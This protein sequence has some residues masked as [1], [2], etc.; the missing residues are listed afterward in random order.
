[1]NWIARLDEHRR[2]TRLGLT[3]FLGRPQAMIAVEGP[4]GTVETVPVPPGAGEVVV[5]LPAAPLAPATALVVDEDGTTRI[6]EDH[7]GAIFYR[8]DDGG[9]V[10]ID[11]L[12]PV[13]AGLVPTPPPQRLGRE[14][15]AFVAGNWQVSE[16]LTDLKEDLKAAIDVQA[17]RERLRYITPGAGQAM[18]YQAKAEEA[19]LL[20]IDTA[21]DPAA[22]PLLSAEV[23]ITAD[24][25][26]E[27]GAVVL[28]SYRAWQVV[29]GAIEAARLG[30]KRLIDLAETEADVRAVVAVWPQ[31]GA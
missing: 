17:E 6:V 30:A 27:V 31:A 24:T 16:T 14:T 28:A 8:A 20:V 1:M 13:P 12:G 26:E 11:Q 19:R 23:G 7:I 5:A 2:V 21:I 10:I 4:D 3:G 15:V 9:Q 22:Y 18:T 29:G 25:L